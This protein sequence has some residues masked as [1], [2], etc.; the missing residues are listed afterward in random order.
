MPL[1]E[2]PHL[3]V[4]QWRK[5]AALTIISGL[6]FV[7]SALE[8]SKWDGPYP[9]YKIGTVGE[10]MSAVATFLAILFAARQL[11][12]ERAQTAEALEV[13]RTSLA[14]ERERWV[15]DQRALVTIYSTRQ[16]GLNMAIVVRNIG[17]GPA[18]DISISLGEDG[19]LPVGA[20]RTSPDASL[21]V[22]MMTSATETIVARVE[23]RQLNTMASID[24]RVSWTNSFDGTTGDSAVSLRLPAT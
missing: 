9:W 20:K 7:A 1:E 21:L 14:L 2:R 23:F 4:E 11:R 6:I 16:D 17:R 5:W 18:I 24:A 3:T 12:S 8:L 22:G 15:D 13:A 19:R 10:W